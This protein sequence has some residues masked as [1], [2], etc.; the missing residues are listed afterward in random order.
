MATESKQSAVKMKP[1]ST[2]FDGSKGKIE[3]SMKVKRIEISSKQKQPVV[4]SKNKSVS[5]VTIK[6]EVKSKSPS[7]SSRTTTTTTTTRVRQK[8]VFSLPGQRCDPP[9]EREPLRIFYESLSKQIPTSEMAEFWMMEHGLLSLERAKKAHE[10]KQRKQKMQRLGTPIKSTTPSTSKPKSSQK[11]QQVS[12]NGDL[13]AKRK[14]SIDS[15]DDDFILSHKRSVSFW[16]Q[17]P[18]IPACILTFTR[19]EFHVSSLAAFKMQGKVTYLHESPSLTCSE[20]SVL[21]L[22]PAS[23]QTN[24]RA[25]AILG[26]LSVCA[27][28]ASSA[29]TFHLK[30]PKNIDSHDQ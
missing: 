20:T 25:F 29:S 9:E 1:R 4:D 12:K 8:K 26:K 21:S 11:Q 6:T 13:K 2:N 16:L 14:I 3:S 23:E 17:Q 30:F 24:K 19:R 10:R 27:P 15:D 28:P 22:G 7:S 5:A 18:I